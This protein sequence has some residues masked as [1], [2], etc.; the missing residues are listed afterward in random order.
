MIV[1]TSTLEC[2]RLVLGSSLIVANIAVWV[3]VYLENEKFP[4]R[5]KDTGWRILILAL[6]AEAAL[7]LLLLV[8]DT[9][10]SNRQK[11]EIVALEAKV[12]PRRLSGE[13]REA[14]SNILRAVPGT[15]I[16]VVSR[17][18][19]PESSD[20]ADDLAA[21]LT[22]S[23]WVH[24]SRDSDWTRSDRGVFIATL[25]GTKLPEAEMLAAALDAANIKHNALVISGEDIHRISP[26]FQP[27]V[28]YLLIGSK[29]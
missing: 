25:S 7:A 20:F 4:Q 14:M 19:D 1:S 15:P 17:L 9:V 28:L 16:I 12:A 22:A 24:V 13:Q 18:L 10:I 11:A 8:V 2:G 26:G 29:P 23:Y 27:G 5:T 21:A 6:A 3:G